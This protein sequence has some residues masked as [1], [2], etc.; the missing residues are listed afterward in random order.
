[1]GVFT[2]LTLQVLVV[3]YVLILATRAITSYPAEPAGRGKWVAVT[4]VSLAFSLLAWRLV[5]LWPFISGG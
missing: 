3:F 2:P 5:A 4:L 1:M